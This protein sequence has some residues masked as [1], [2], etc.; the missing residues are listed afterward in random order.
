MKF[1]FLLVGMFWLVAA[2][3]QIHPL[4]NATFWDDENELPISIL[5][6]STLLYGKELKYYHFEPLD[7]DRS[8]LKSLSPL[9][10]QDTTYLV[11]EAGGIV[12]RYRDKAFT[13]IDN[14]FSHKNQYGSIDFVHNNKIF[15]LGGYGI[16]TDKNILTRYDFAAKEWFLEQTTG[17]VPKCIIADIFQIIGNEL[18][19]INKGCRDTNNDRKFNFEDRVYKLNLNN[20]KF[21][22]LGKLKIDLDAKIHSVAHLNNDQVLAFKRSLKY[23]IDLKKN[24]LHI[25]GDDFPSILFRNFKLLEYDKNKFNFITKNNGSQKL[26]YVEINE[27]SILDSIKETKPLYVT[28]SYTTKK[29]LFFIGLT[30]FLVL[31]AYF[32]YYLYN[33]YN[34]VLIRTSSENIS[35]RNKRIDELS[36]KAQELLI[37]LAKANSSIELAEILHHLNIQAS[38]YETLKK[39]RKKLLDEI[40]EKLQKHIGDKAQNIFIIK[41]SS[42]DKRHKLIRLNPKLIHIKK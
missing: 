40:V 2:Q 18:F 21:K 30:L 19:F 42:A 25:I 38:S 15:L 28:P 17:D 37:H 29:L 16:F 6:D 10:V 32:A 33:R 39:K 7:I 23:L 31:L 12:V 24:K 34:K 1:L 9:Q 27:A 20:L 26:K 3:S 41:R 22:Y 14:S 35:F 11:D 36:P 5:N 4:N 8:K 13:R